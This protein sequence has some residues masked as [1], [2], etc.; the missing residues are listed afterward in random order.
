[1]KILLATYFGVPHFGGVWTYMTQ[2]KRALERRGHVVDIMGQAPDTG[3]IYIL[4]Q[5]RVFNKDHVL[6]L[7]KA[8]LNPSNMPVLHSN[9]W[10]RDFEMHRYIL[11]LAAS[12]F[13]L[14]KYDIIHTQDVISTY[15]FS[16]VKPK[17]VPLVGSV[18]GTLTKAMM[19]KL[20]ETGE[21]HKGN[22][23]QASNL[24]KYFQSLEYHGAVSSNL[25]IIST[26]WLKRTFTNELAV[27]SKKIRVFQYGI[28]IPSFINS[29]PAEGTAVRR[30]PGKKVIIYTGR[31]SYMKGLHN[32]LPALAK[33]KQVRK[34]WVCWIVGDGDKRGELERQSKSLGLGEEVKFLGRRGDV[35]S[36]L[37]LSDI[38]VTPTLRDNMPFALI[39]AQVAGKP[40]VVTNVG[41]VPEMVIN[42]STAMV[43]KAG[44]KEGLF[45]HLRMLVEN[46]NLRKKM[47]TNA[48][49]HGANH[50][51]IDLMIKR[52]LKVYQN[53]IKSK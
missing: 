21:H 16:R 27:P 17:H 52:L 5:N 29:N 8:K 24:K 32:L 1:M 50:W 34:D 20:I 11:E 4:D 41:G 19:E 22:I 35:A 39:E 49:Q 9:Q 37:K 2:V 25:T 7:L 30:P 36:L 6:P 13:G 42:G 53:L 23:D 26:N 10:I 46:D 45:N 43:S 14:D 48:E 38:Y 44:D 31:L 47:G 33:L 51:S 3:N 12:Y 18:H 15:A 28:D 40:A